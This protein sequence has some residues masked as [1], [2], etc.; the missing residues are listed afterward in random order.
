M[1]TPLGAIEDLLTGEDEDGAPVLDLEIRDL[2]NYLIA[3]VAAKGLRLV[4]QEQVGW[5]HI[6][7]RFLIEGT[8]QRPPMEDFDPV[9]HDLV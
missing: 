2:A 1:E 4:R 3:G 7:A 9:W 6:P 8:E 5:L